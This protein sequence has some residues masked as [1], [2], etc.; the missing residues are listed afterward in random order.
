MNPAPAEFYASLAEAA[1]VA[2]RSLEA[3]YRQLRE[4]L[5]RLCRV[6]VSDT[7]LQM[8]DLGA[9]LNYLARERGWTRAELNALHTFRL[10]AAAVL[11]RHE[12]ARADLFGRDLRTVC[13]TVERL[14][15][16]PV[17]EPL[18]RLLPASEAKVRHPRA[19]RFFKR[20]RVSFLRAD[21]AY[22]YVNPLDFVADESVRVRYGVPGVNDMFRPTVS[23][24]WEHAQLNLLDVSVDEQ[25]DYV[26]GFLILE[27]DYLVDISSLAECF[28]PYGSH[29]ANYWLARLTP[30][31]NALPLLLGNLANLFLDEWIHA[32]GEV[33]YLSVMQKGFRT[34]ALELAAAD[35]LG[36]PEAERRFF[37]DC[38]MHFDH[39]R[40]VVTQTFR[41]P[42]Y[43][44]DKDDAVLEP[45][46]ICEA[47]GV[48]G[49]LDYMQRNMESFIEMKS[50]RADEYGGPDHI[51]PRENNRVQMLLYMAVLEFSMGVDHRRQHP[52]LLYTRYPLLYPA[53]ASW[54]A[55]KRVMDVRNRIVAGEFEVQRHDDVR[56]T[57]L[58]LDHIKAEVMNERGL[59]GRLWRDYLRPPIDAFRTSVASLSPLGRTYFFSLYRFVTKELYTSKSGD[60]DYDGRA[61]AAAL[62]LSTLAEK[63]EAGE[64]LYDLRLVENRADQPRKAY[65]VLS[66]PMYADDFCSNFRRGDA[67]VLYERNVDTDR[68]TNKLVFK[69]NIERLEPDRITIRFRA[70]Q[71]NLSVLPA[72]SRYAVEHDV[73]DVTFR[74]LY[75]GLRAFA[76][77]LPQRRDLLLGIR[78]PRFD[79]SY[80]AAIGVAADDFERVALKACAARDFFLLVGPP[81]TGKTSQAL[82][83]MVEMLHAN[84]ATQLLL[85]A[86]TNR[87]VDEICR[88]L[89]SIRPEVSFIRIGNELACEEAY[90]PY[91]LENVLDGCRRR[92]EVRRRIESCRLFVGTVASVSTKS[93]L[94]R[95]KRFDVALVDEA[96]QILE[97]HLL[98]VLCAK[99]PDGNNAVE[100]FILIG[101]H[102][103]LPAVVQQSEAQ[104]RVKE[105]ELN[106]IGLTNWRDSL[107]E[108]LYRTYADRCPR[109]VDHL[110]RQGR[111]NPAVAAFPNRAFYED[112]LLP[113]G[114]PH[115][116]D[117]L[118]LPS[119]YVSPWRDLLLR[120]MAFIPSRPCVG[121]V[122]GKTHPEEASIVAR[123]AAEVY[124]SRPDAFDASRTLGVI[125]PYRSQIALIRREL[126]L[127]GIAA[128]NDVMVDTVERYQGSERDVII[129]S[130][131]VNH[132]WQLHFLC[133]VIHEHG[134]AID[135]K[136]NVALTRARRQLFLVG[137]PS[138]LAHN[139]I[140]AELL[141]S[142]EVCEVPEA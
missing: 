107:F 80:D 27:P 93:E 11:N 115:Q 74:S 96:T 4:C 64:I 113:L 138:V 49:R 88:S 24:L 106:A 8:T 60:I 42:G 135:R 51:E 118:T 77:A 10:T 38:R 29:P 63:C 95:L 21:E 3:A 83:R 99:T 140:Y 127:Q 56:H 124:R 36:N 48:Q 12:M 119:G 133:N 37:A 62:W 41:Q 120:R 112:R 18:M 47:L 30:P 102:K 23:A 139:P 126:A 43:R 94:F 132:P 31:E 79:A 68:V 25:G 6:S 5:E 17:P 39:I 57:A 109:A 84:P 46:Y 101:D 40:T 52:Y 50:G 92:T 32:Q 28:R 54:A 26:P 73:S 20:L 114:L 129:Y 75:H 91:L 67:V 128:L 136:L 16:M 14:F 85:L 59:T 105:P 2:G 122:S 19:V 71:R 111:M 108:R 1:S 55:V 13:L 22:L 81:G 70:A 90:R 65:V 7:A 142:V 66:V 137:C 117:Q 100:R 69:G 116:C 121:A 123:L 131:C 34:Y 58:C 125:T 45:A 9:R 15:G 141:R 98:P 110:C 61:G 89:C 97:P 87:A 104:T 130:F 76:E 35:E 134:H 82:R 72:E 103:Q 78:E 33:D 44:L 53:S 86:Y